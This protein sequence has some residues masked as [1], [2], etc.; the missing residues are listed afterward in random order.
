VVTF[1]GRES[2]RARIL[3]RGYLRATALNG[4]VAHI[5]A[6]N[7]LFRTTPA[8]AELLANTDV[9]AVCVKSGAS[10]EVAKALTDAGIEKFPN[11]VVVSLQNGVKNADILRSG[12]P[13]GIVVSDGMVPFNVV[14]LEE[15]GTGQ[16]AEFHQ[17]EKDV[18]SRVVSWQKCIHHFSEHSTLC[19]ISI[20]WPGLH[21]PQRKAAHRCHQAR[22]ARQRGVRSHSRGPI[23]Q[24][25]LQSE[26]RSFHR[27]FF[28]E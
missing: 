15:D 14:E 22:W 19:S 10:S 8:D 16:M 13:A 7:V 3:K 17:G 5:D 4:Q 21:R 11:I 25:A 24:A 1:V 28:F 18:I 26:Q 6:E 12:L 23:H 9:V 2:L 27:R 20:P